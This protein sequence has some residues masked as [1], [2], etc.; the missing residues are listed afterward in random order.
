MIPISS[1]S[2]VITYAGRHLLS[3]WD[4]KESGSLSRLLSSVVP[5]L[6]LLHSVE[7]GSQQTLSGRHSPDI[8]VKT[9][10]GERERQDFFVCI[11]F[12]FVF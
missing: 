5:L 2:C 4:D 11:M 8:I 12:F 9:K 3:E 1:S 7:C 6:L 10:R